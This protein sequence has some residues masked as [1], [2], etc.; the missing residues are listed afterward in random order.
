MRFELSIRG[1]ITFLAL[2]V[3]LPLTA[4]TAL[5]IVSDFRETANAARL[6][7]D[8]LASVTAAGVAQ[9]AREAD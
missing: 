6:Q 7:V 1:Q 3:A 8:R 9:Y 2:G 4:L 5:I